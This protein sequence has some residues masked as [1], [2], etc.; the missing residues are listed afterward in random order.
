MRK[1][2]KGGGGGGGGADVNT[3][4]IPSVKK[5]L[6][7]GESEEGESIKEEDV[8]RAREAVANAYGTDLGAKGSLVPL[9][10]HHWPEKKEEETK[11][12]NDIPPTSIPSLD[13]E[14]GSAISDSLSGPKDSSSSYAL[15][16]WGLISSPTYITSHIRSRSS[17]SSSNSGPAFILFINHRLVSHPSLRRAVESTYADVLRGA[18]GD[19]SLHNATMRLRPPFIYLHLMMP[20]RHV[21]VNCHPS[22]ETVALLHEDEIVRRVCVA[23]RETLVGA[24]GTSRVFKVQSLVPVGMMGMAGIKREKKSVQHVDNENE[25][26]EEETDSKRRKMSVRTRATNKADDDKKKFAKAISEIKKENS[27]RIILGDITSSSSSSSDEAEEPKMKGRVKKSNSQKNNTPTKTPPRKN[28]YSKPSTYSDPKRL[29]RTNLAA[30]SGAIEPFLVGTPQR[31]SSGGTAG[32]GKPFIKS[33]WN[34]PW[35]R[36]GTT[37]ASEKR[38]QNQTEL[39]ERDVVTASD[40]EDTPT[41]QKDKL[42]SS[43]DCDGPAE[44]TPLLSS[45]TSIEADRTN[46]ASMIAT[47]PQSHMQGCPG[48][49]MDIDFSQP[50]AFALALCRCHEL[51]GELLPRPPPPPPPKVKLR[52][53]HPTPFKYTSIQEMRAEVGS[54]ASCRELTNRIRSGCFVGAVG[55]SRSLV[56]SGTELLLMDHYALG[57]ELFYQLALMQFGGHEMASIGFGEEGGVDVLRCLVHALELRDAEEEH[58]EDREKMHEIAGRMAVQATMCLR[59]HRVML[60]GEQFFSFSF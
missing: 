2:G 20:G 23:V 10:L 1:S 40:V 6:G 21:D 19:T 39:F 13:D 26:D 12:N 5:A 52:R 24:A 34:R 60:S 7:E 59:A 36:V 57:R 51:G 9:S 50:G 22:K 27:G 47:P 31:S 44:S 18:Q 17:S 15:S 49:P 29:V 25:Q 30:K 3:A 48:A 45:L 16:V 42:A 33:P 11:N 32:K 28:P 38:A 35:D 58:E 46:A 41:Q 55:R 4:G 43:S 53:R 37:P 8:E 14:M 54:R 56:Q